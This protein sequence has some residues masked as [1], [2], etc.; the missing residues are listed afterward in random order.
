MAVRYLPL[1]MK[2]DGE[3]G[4]RMNVLH[5]HIG[6]LAILGVSNES[7]DPIVL[8]HVEVVRLWSDECRREQDVEG[9]MMLIHPTTS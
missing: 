4:V 9:K 1:G 8:C 3:K 5:A 7:R 6:A 2:H